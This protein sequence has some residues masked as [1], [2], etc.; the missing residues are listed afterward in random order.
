MS[1]IRLVQ[2]TLLVA[3][4]RVFNSWLRETTQQLASYRQDDNNETQPTKT[5]YRTVHCTTTK[6]RTTTKPSESSL[7]NLRDHVK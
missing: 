7:H 3:V 2:Y 5:N 4:G 1:C 6:Q